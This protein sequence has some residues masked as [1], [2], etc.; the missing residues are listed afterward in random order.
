[1]DLDRFQR[2]LEERRLR[3]QTVQAY[4]ACVRIAYELRDPVKAVLEARS[5]GRR[6]QYYAAL[7][8]YAAFLGG[9][10]GAELH[11]QL[12]NL[13]RFRKP[14]KPP[15]RPLSNL[16]WKALLEEA[17]QEEEPLDLILALLVYTGLRSSDI[18][19]IE[20]DQVRE[21]LETDIIYLAQ[22]GGDY[23]PFPVGGEVKKILRKL[24]EE[25]E[26]KTIRN[27]LT[28]GKSQRA[29]YMVLYRGLHAAA[30]RAGLEED[31]RNPHLLRAT[32]AVQL[33]KRTKDANAVQK[34]LGH[35]DLKN[36]EPYLRYVDTEDLGVTYQQL[37][38][39]RE[40]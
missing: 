25:W 31:R 38:E 14:E 32:A 15:R 12:L 35:K 24:D 3:P 2:W 30:E 22:K 9:P 28:A 19:N 27:L 36:I 8:Q 34:Y 21:G 1:M 23:R 29:A 11:N 16:E 13:P 33:Y 7:K 6:Q 26:W 4:V 17:G 10:E 37:E 20:H 5:R 18:I 40:E 39:S